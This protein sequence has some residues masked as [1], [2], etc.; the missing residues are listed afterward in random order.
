MLGGNTDVRIADTHS[1]M[2]IM[3]EGNEKREDPK[4]QHNN[5]HQSQTLHTLPSATRYGRTEEPQPEPLKP[6]E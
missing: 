3:R 6:G 1:M 2:V 5:S 4:H